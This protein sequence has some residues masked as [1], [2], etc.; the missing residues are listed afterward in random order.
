MRGRGGSLRLRPTRWQVDAKLTYPNFGCRGP[1]ISRDGP[2]FLVSPP[3]R[4]RVFPVPVLD[5][6]L[7]TNS[8]HGS[9]AWMRSRIA[10]MARLDPDLGGDNRHDADDLRLRCMPVGIEVVG[11]PRKI[12]V[13]AVEAEAE[14]MLSP[15][16]RAPP[17]PA[18]RLVATGDRR[19]AR[20]G[21]DVAVRVDGSGLSQPAHR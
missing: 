13:H 5:L 17:T 15:L 9:S 21:Y 10:L 16:R 6:L 18:G 7:L 14:Q 11:R 4:P 3:P 2:Q 19:K 8:R 1:A 20:N 12:L